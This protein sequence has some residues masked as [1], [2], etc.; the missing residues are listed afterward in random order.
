MENVSATT[1][2]AAQPDLVVITVKS[3]AISVPR[4]NEIA[5][6]A[7]VSRRTLANAMKGGSAEDVISV[8][9]SFKLF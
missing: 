3:V 1:S 9:I 7:S 2:V 4:A 6:T 5:T 8:R